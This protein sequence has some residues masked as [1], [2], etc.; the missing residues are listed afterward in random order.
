M[1]EINNCG[2][3]DREKHSLKYKVRGSRGLLHTVIL[4]A[5]TLARCRRED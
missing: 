2:W 5:A 1:T 4:A 3:G